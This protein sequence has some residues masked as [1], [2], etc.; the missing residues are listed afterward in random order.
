MGAVHRFAVFRYPF[1]G[2]KRRPQRLLLL[3]VNC[4]RNLLYIKFLTIIRNLFKMLFPFRA[5]IH[6]PNFNYL[7]SSLSYM[8]MHRLFWFTFI[9]PEIYH[10][11]TNTKNLRHFQN[12]LGG[13]IYKLH[14]TPFLKYPETLLSLHLK[15]HYFARYNQ[16]GYKLH[17]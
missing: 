7:G 1:C 8:N 6:S 5:N 4:C 13:Q 9:R 16:E 3:K 14:E 11:R 17:Q 15:N 12:H 10:I 2:L